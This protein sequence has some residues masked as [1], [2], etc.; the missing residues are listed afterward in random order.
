MRFL[1]RIP[2]WLLWFMVIAPLVLAL[3]LNLF[4]IIGGAF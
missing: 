4:A 2:T 1:L 3:V